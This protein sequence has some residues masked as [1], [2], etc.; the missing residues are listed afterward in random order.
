MKSAA[1]GTGVG[2]LAGVAIGNSG[3]AAA[4]GAGVGLVFGA[5]SGA[6]ATG[7][8][9]GAAQNRYDTAY[10]QCM[11]G[12]GHKVAVSAMNGYATQGEAVTYASP[13]PPP[14]SPPPPSAP[15]AYPTAPYAAPPVA[16]P[17]TILPPAG[18]EQSY[19]R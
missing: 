15:S 14:A 17:G 5:A 3:R 2:A 12:H 6:G 7:R 4:T 16:A 9:A 19:S 10:A 18:A 11:Y 8:S 1:I 13:P